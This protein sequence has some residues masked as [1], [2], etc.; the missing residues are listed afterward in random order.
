MSPVVPD[1]IKVYN[2]NMVQVDRRSL[3]LRSRRRTLMRGKKQWIKMLVMLLACTEMFSAMQVCAYAES[4]NLTE[5][6]K[7]GRA[8]LFDG[9]YGY[10]LLDDGTAELTSYLGSDTNVV[11]P[12]EVEGAKVTSIHSNL[13]YDYDVLESVE[14]PDTVTNI[15]YQAFRGCYKLTSIELPESVETIGEHAFRECKGLKHVV[16]PKKLTTVS[17]WLFFD[18]DN[19]E[20]VEIPSGVAKIGQAAFW[21]CKNL[22]EITIPS[23]VTSIGKYAFYECRSLKS[24][25]VPSGVKK[26]LEGT[27]SGCIRMTSV[28]LPSGVVLIDDNAFFDCSGLKSIKMPDKLKEVGDSAFSG[29]VKLKRI[30][31]PKTVKKIREDAFYRCN[32]L[33]IYCTKNSVAHKYAKSNEIPYSTGEKKVPVSSI[34]LSEKKVTLQ[35]GDKRVLEV[36]ISPVD[37][38][39]ASVT[40]KSSDK[41][42]ATVNKKGKVKAVGNG[43]AVITATAADGSGKKATCKIIVP[44]KITYKLG[45]GTNSKK[46]PSAYYNEKVTLKNPVREGYVFKGWYTDKKYKNKITVIK[47][48]TKK[49]YTL[50]AKWKKL[51]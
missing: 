10:Q 7:L 39:K 13:F 20:S 49:N 33:V 37:A 51:N 5:T 34:R 24:V 15:G 9:D 16:L 17:G 21:K 48:G 4:T 27:F 44:Y 42:V 47:K 25:V 45:G 1:K 32:K 30:V 11:I 18:C 29:C 22:K 31:L 46:N 41:K 28:V 14:I 26:I 38:T 43:V 23:G 40:W 12:S 3:F 2:C 8:M 19:L 6:E 36:L 50:Y 35:K